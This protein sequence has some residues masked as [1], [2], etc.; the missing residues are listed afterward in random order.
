[1]QENDHIRKAMRRSGVQHW[2]LAAYLG[3]SEM[4]LTRWLRKPL[5]AEDESRIMDAIGKLE[6]E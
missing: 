5:T 1:M 6:V 2:R 3:I 4:T